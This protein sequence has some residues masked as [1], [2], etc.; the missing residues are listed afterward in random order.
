MRALSSLNSYSHL[1]I[2]NQ[3]LSGQASDFTL[4]KSF[5]S[6]QKREH[7]RFWNDDALEPGL[8]VSGAVRETSAAWSFR[9]RRFIHH[10]DADLAAEREKVWRD[11]KLAVCVYNGYS[12]QRPHAARPLKN[13]GGPHHSSA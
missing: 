7:I 13:P 3:W 8:W 12:V 1:P 4:Q 5:D 10:V 11:L 6:Y 9:M 2:S